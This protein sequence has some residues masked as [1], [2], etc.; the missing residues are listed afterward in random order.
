M[1]MLFSGKG[2][3]WKMIQKGLCKVQLVKNLNKPS[4][5]IEILR[6]EGCLKGYR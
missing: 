4:E 2:K 5:S 6:K 1:E 3:S